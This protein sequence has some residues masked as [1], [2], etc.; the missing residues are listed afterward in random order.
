MREYTIKTKTVD[1]TPFDGWMTKLEMRAF[2]WVDKGYDTT[3]YDSYDIDVDLDNNKAT[4][5]RRSST[6]HVFKRINPYSHNLIF[7]LLELIMSITAWIRRKLVYIFAGM[8]V[9]VVLISLITGDYSGLMIA[10]E[11][12]FLI[13]VPS[14]FLALFGYLTRLI[15]RLDKKLGDALE[16]NGYSREQNI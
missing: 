1:I 13:Y 6:Y 14:L 9:L 10:G 15:F 5:T 8:T 11:I 16:K 3:W 7:M 2:G 4:A 12:V